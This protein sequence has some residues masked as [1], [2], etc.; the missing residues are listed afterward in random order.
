MGTEYAM[1]YKLVQTICF[2]RNDMIN[3]FFLSLKCTCKMG[4]LEKNVNLP[5][6][7]E[8]VQKPLAFCKKKGLVSL[9][10]ETV[11]NK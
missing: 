4:F 11:L 1:E 2:F 6:T 9:T 8:F 7:A 3:S 5:H 10:D